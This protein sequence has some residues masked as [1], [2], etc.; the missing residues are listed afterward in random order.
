MSASQDPRRF[1]PSVDRMLRS[2]VLRAALE[3]SPRWAVLEAVRDELDGVRAGRVPLPS[4]DGREA[5]IESLA[6]RAAERVGDV[7]RYSLVG[8]INATGVVLHTNL[9]RA[10]L[11]ERAIEHVAEMARRYSNLELDLESGERGS[12]YVHVESLLCELTGAEAA[13]VVNNNAAAVVLG[14]TALAKGGEVIISRGEL[15]EIGGS[16]RIPAIME[17]SGATLVEVGTT[18]R[19]HLSDYERA[20]TPRTSAIL[21]VHASNYRIVGFTMEA[22]VPELVSIA[23]SKNL[24]VMHDLGSGCLIDLSQ[25]GMPREPTVREAVAEGADVVTFS[26]DKLLGGP[27][28]GAIAGRRE[29]VDRLKKHQLL[30]ALRVDKLT[31]AAF[32]A[33]LRTYRDARDPISEIPTLA[34]LAADRGA[35]AVRAERIA[36]RLRRDMGEAVSTCEGTSRAGGGSLP[37]ADLPTMLVAVTPPNGGAD[38]VQTVLRQ[39][40]PSVMVRVLEQKILIDPRTVFEDEEEMMCRRIAE[41]MKGDA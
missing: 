25:Y 31:L 35:L 8:V 36:A 34:M 11:A 33:T 24:L 2:P 21:K 1:V 7:G 22:K 23:R 9:G 39:G 37:E 27:Q 17:Q 14:L 28:I 26:G 4:E 13:L 18:N 5:W 3:H 19:T 20:I 30:R 10:P 16:F 12:R 6:A 15:V 32:E 38:R 41:T 40:T 29:V